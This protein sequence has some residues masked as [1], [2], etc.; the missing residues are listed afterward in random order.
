M[1]KAKTTEHDRKQMARQMG[2]SIVDNCRISCRMDSF[3]TEGLPAD[4]WKAPANSCVVPTADSGDPAVPRTPHQC[5][6][7]YSRMGLH[8]NSVREHEHRPG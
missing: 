1:I 2:Q 4:N 7:T 5:S 3:W 6:N 8:T